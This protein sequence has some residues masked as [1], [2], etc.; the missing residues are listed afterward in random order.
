MIPRFSFMMEVR[1]G[2]KSK[3]GGPEYLVIFFLYSFLLAFLPR[4]GHSKF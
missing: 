4:I 1:K 3:K 2:V